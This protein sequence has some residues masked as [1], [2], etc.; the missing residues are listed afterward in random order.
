MEVLSSFPADAVG[1][2]P[3]RRNMRRAAGGTTRVFLGRPVACIM[4][5]IV[6]LQGCTPTSTAQSSAKQKAARVHTLGASGEEAR[7]LAAATAVKHAARNADTLKKTRQLFQEL[8]EEHSGDIPMQPVVVNH[9]LTEQVA[10]KIAQ[11]LRK[12]P[13]LTAPGL[14]GTRLEHLAV[15]A[16]DPWVLEQLAATIAAIALGNVPD[17]V[18]Q[19]LRVAEAVSSEKAVGGLRPLL[20]GCTYKRL[21]LRALMQVKKEAVTEA[22]GTHQ[23]G[24]GRK[25]GAE[26]VIKSLEAQAEVHPRS[27]FMKVDVKAAFQRMHRRVAFDEVDTH[28]TDLALILSRWYSKPVDHLWRNADGRFEKIT[29]CRGFDQGCPLAAAAFSITQ[30][31]VLDELLAEMQF[32]DQSS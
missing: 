15:A 17:E 18:L 1:K 31:M 11:L 23:Y 3:K 7:A 8:P 6:G 5:H 10:T 16:D 24:V 21:G 13:R 12:H 2:V 27:M 9:Q 32:K 30:R 20:V 29:S 28:D 25:A 14:L 22:V 19:T 4:G 26:I